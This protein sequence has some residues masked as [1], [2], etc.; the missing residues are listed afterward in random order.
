MNVK[1][2]VEF[3]DKYDFSD[4]N[5]MFD[6]AEK[7][8]N[9]FNS[10]HVY[11]HQCMENSLFAEFTMAKTPQ[12]KVVDKI[13]KEF[14]NVMRNHV[15]LTIN[16]PKKT[17]QIVAAVKPSD[18]SYTIKQGQYLSFIHY[19]SKLNKQAP[20]ESDF[21]KFF[22]VSP[23]SVHSMILRLEEKGFI[24]RIPNSSRSIKLLI[25]RSEIPDLD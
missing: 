1:V 14:K 10:I 11:H 19:F 4:R 8:T 16:F 21:Q 9:E 2:E 25:D 22:G 7:L 3:K 23:P 17:I 18:K 24:S 6:V 13:A 15:D 12:S 20:A 5:D